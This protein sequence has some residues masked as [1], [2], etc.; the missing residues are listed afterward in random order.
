ME[1]KIII[2]G[3]LALALVLFIIAPSLILPLVWLC[4]IIK[5][6]YLRIKSRLINGKGNFHTIN[7]YK[8]ESG[9]F[10]KVPLI[11]Y[12]FSC[13]PVILIMWPFFDSLGWV[14]S[15]LLSNIIYLALLFV[16]IR[17]Y[18]GK[19]DNYSSV[20]SIIKSH[21]AY[22]KAIFLP[23]S[24]F[25]ALSGVVISFMGIIT[26]FKDITIPLKS[27]LDNPS[28]TSILPEILKIILGFIILS[29]PT[30][31]I[32]YLALQ[33]YQYSI[34]YGTPYATFAKHII[35]KIRK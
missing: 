6:I 23:I 17:L 14:G 25:I 1:I 22:L 12:S 28:L 29:L 19:A 10:F 5:S 32:A 4:S 27:I 11:F 26:E 31:F 9:S 35:R 3:I 15:Y 30:Q 18:Y 34:K 20:N 8:S 7:E 13:I 2:E 21:L 33:L 16:A 24:F